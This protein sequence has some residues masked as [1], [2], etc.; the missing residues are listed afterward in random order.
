MSASMSNKTFM[1]PDFLTTFLEE[2]RELPGLWQGRSADYL[3][4][5]KR[6]EV[7]DLLVQFTFPSFFYSLF[8]PTHRIHLVL[9]PLLQFVS[10]N[11][12]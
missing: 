4:R 2:C 12:F 5:A 10:M 9:S 8:S 1:S 3:N 7:W 6:D 11:S